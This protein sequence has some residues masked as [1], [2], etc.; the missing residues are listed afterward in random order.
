MSIVE[1][2]QQIGARVAQQ[3]GSAVVRIGQGWG[4]GTGVVVGDGLVVTN[5]HT[6]RDETTTVTFADGHALQGRVV[7]VDVDGD[8]VVL[9]VATEGAAPISWEPVDAPTIGT[10]VFAVANPGGRG[11]RVSFGTVSGVGRTFRGPRGRRIT[12]AVE[13]TAPLGRGSSGGPLVDAEGRLVGINTHRL[14][15]GFYLA[16]PADAEL[17]ARVDALARGE[18]ATRL[19]L[20]V[21]LAPSHVARRLRRSVGLAERDGL[22]VRVVE[23]ASPAARAD[24]RVGDLLISAS[25]TALG[26]SDELLDILGGLGPDGVLALR[27]VRGNDEL[28]VSVTF[29]APDGTEGSA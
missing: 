24:L 3:A 25:G 9:A 17:K 18:S 23:P 29:A 12:G 7:G 11:L 22:L 13:H 10:P 4:R 21:G 1:E 26:S 20:G 6:L 16:L 2:L 28:D 5:A 19:H 14:G 15:E 27:V 8:L